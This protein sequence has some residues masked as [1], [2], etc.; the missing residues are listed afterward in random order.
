M[1]M[2]GLAW[3]AASIITYSRHISL[4]LEKAGPFELLI[5]TQSQETFLTFPIPYRIE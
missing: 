4:D 2:F 3:E 5:V 1:K